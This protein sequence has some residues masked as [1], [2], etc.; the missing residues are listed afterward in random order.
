MRGHDDT[1][2][3]EN[4]GVFLGLVSFA[5]SLDS[6]LSK[7][8]KTA[9]VY[10][11]KMNGQVMNFVVCLM[12]I[13][14]HVKIAK[15]FVLI[16]RVLKISQSFRGLFPPWTP[17]GHCP[18][19]PPGALRWPLDPTSS[20]GALAPV[21]P[22]GHPDQPEYPICPSKYFDHELPLSLGCPLPPH[23]PLRNFCKDLYR[24]VQ[25]GTTACF[26][27]L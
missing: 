9:T 26:P 14:C 7:H 25:N 12:L 4:P 6:V 13:K 11:K 10:Y 27:N 17:L 24:P 22:L 20:Q 2:D 21:A 19:T 18:W 5:A 15:C 16:P 23:Q 3:S 1:D 8:L